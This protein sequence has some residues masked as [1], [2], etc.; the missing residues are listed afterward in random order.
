MLWM[1]SLRDLYGFEMRRKPKLRELK[2]IENL[3]LTATQVDQLSQIDHAAVWV[4]YGQRWKTGTG[5][6]Y[7]RT[8]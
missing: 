1:H 4:S 2:D 3:D 5:R 8:L 6:E 7:L